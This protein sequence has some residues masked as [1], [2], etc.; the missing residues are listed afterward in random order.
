LI[1]LIAEAIFPVPIAE[2]VLTYVPFVLCKDEKRES[3]SAECTKAV[4][5]IVGNYFIRSQAC[6]PWNPPLLQS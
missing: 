6:K 5:A 1:E 2:E 3:S 4:A